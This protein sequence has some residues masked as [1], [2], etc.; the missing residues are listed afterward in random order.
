MNLRSPGF[1]R[2]LARHLEDGAAAAEALR[3]GAA[4]YRSLFLESPIPILEVDLT[5]F[6]R[7]IAALQGPGT[8]LRRQF[9]ERPGDFA[10]SVA[11]IR[12]RRANGAALRLAGARRTGRLSAVLS[13]MTAGERCLQLLEPLLALL[14]GRSP[15]AADYRTET[16]GGEPLVLA[17]QWSLPPERGEDWSRAFVSAVEVTAA[18]AA[19]QREEELHRRVARSERLI[20]LGIMAAGVA[21]EINNLNQAILVS[22]QLLAE[23]WRSMRVILDG[24]H[25]SHGDFLLGE[26]EY[27]QMRELIPNYFAGILDGSQRIDRIVSSLKE[28]AGREQARQQPVELNHVVS[29]ALILL[30]NVTKNATA[31][32]KVELAD[33]L[34]AVYGSFQRLEQVVVN[35]VQ[36][37]CQALPDRE[38]EIRVSTRYDRLRSRAVLEVA[39]QGVGIPPEALERIREPFF[40]TRREAGG[41]GLGLSVSAAIVEEHRGW[42]DFHSQP[43]EGTVVTLALP[44]RAAPEGPG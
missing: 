32:L 1:A 21:H 8:D 6:R 35:L 14:E 10:D 2:W 30:A 42:L 43:G 27:S 19:R 31:R 44:V 15:S 25:R 40:T 7:R 9:R 34:P 24:Y 39:D 16:A 18:R 23:A 41:T 37:A 29:S 38:R 20:S 26:L 12:V 36:N 28:Y 17:V 4:A 22:G 13:R 11:R 33:A 5:E 3:A